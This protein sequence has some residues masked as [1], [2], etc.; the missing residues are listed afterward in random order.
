MLTIHNDGPATE[1]MV[2]TTD[3]KQLKQAQAKRGTTRIV[4]T[5][6]QTYLVKVG[7]RTFKVAM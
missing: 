3:G 6:G 2:Y 4:L 7:P 1:A 5:E